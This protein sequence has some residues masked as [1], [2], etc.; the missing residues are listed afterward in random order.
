MTVINPGVLQATGGME[1]LIVTRAFA[2]VDPLPEG[3]MYLRATAS[4][5]EHTD[6]VVDPLGTRAGAA[7]GHTQVPP[8]PRAPSP[9]LRQLARPTSNR[10]VMSPTLTLYRVDVDA[11]ESEPR[12]PS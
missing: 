6:A 1:H 2:S 10:E 3:R 8:Q 5:Q 7:L 12:Q 4:L 9:R 11:P